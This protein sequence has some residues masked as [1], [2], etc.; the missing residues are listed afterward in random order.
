MQKQIQPNMLFTVTVASGCAA[1]PDCPCAPPCRRVRS[2][3]SAQSDPSVAQVLG[4]YDLLQQVLH[5]LAPG[6]GCDARTRSQAAQVCRL[7][8]QVARTLPLSMQLESPLSDKLV[9]L[10][11]PNPLMLKFE[12]IVLY[13]RPLGA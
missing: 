10:L 2:R 7:W 1:C 4:S 8:R 6:N 11:L 12:G 9:G 3:S 13:G 5:K